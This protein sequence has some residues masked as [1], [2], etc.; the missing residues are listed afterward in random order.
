MAEV[1]ERAGALDAGDAER[2]LAQLVEAA[3]RGQFFWAVTMFAVAGTRPPS[4]HPLA[5]GRNQP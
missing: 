2:W 1:A 3:T 4:Q 5:A